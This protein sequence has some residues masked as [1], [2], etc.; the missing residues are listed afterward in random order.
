MGKRFPAMTPE[1]I[2]FIGRQ[3]LFFVG[4]AALSAEHR[5]NISP[6]GYDCLRVLSESRVAYLDL[7]GS[8]NDT[9]AHLLEN[10][11]ITFR[12]RGRP[13]GPPTLWARAGGAAHRRG[14]GR[15]GAALH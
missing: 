13:D 15:A 6:K 5:V 11:R 8:G 12:I 14:V 2:A 7:T 9:S 3:K 4:S 10:G 1:Q